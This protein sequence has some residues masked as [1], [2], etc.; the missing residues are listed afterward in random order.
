MTTHLTPFVCNAMPPRPT[1]SRSSFLRQSP[2]NRLRGDPSELSAERIRTTRWWAI[3]FG[4]AVALLVSFTPVQFGAASTVLGPSLIQLTSDLATSVQIKAPPDLATS[5]PAL[6]TM[7][8][9]DAS[10]APARLACYPKSGDINLSI[11]ATA[12][13]KCAYGNTSATRMMLLT[14]D[15]QAGMWLPAFDQLGKDLGWKVI[16]LAHPE[17]PPWGVPNAPKWIIQGQFTVADCTQYQVNVAKWVTS[18]APAVVVLAGR[19]HPV[20]WNPNAPLVLSQLQPRV[21]AAIRSFQHATTSVITLNPMPSY[22]PSWT[23]YQPVTCLAYIRPITK[24]EGSPAQMVT[25]ILKQAMV[26]AA[27]AT[28]STQLPIYKLFCTDRKCALF[29]KDGTLNRLVY[30]DPL[31]MNRYYSQWIAQGLETLIGPKLP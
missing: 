6:V 11:P 14:G 16:F 17:C 29:V 28:G 18:N 2:T 26:G 10:V 5:I 15:S 21:I 20:G 12:S 8:P 13:I 31:H 3:P 23:A 4:V 24:C 27:A 7:T 25:P 19:A 1:S 9:A 22:T 30:Y